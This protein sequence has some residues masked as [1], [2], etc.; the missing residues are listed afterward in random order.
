M[1]FIEK[2]GQVL[3]LFL[4]PFGGGIPAGVLL[5]QKLSLQWPWM[6]VLYFISDLILAVVFE[7]ILRY[8][9]HLSYHYSFLMKMRLAFRKWRDHHPQLSKQTKNPFVLIG[10]AFGVDPMTG[11]AAAMASGYGFIGGWLIAIAGDM[12]Y[13]SVIMISTLWL[14]HILG[15]GTWTIIIILILMVFIPKVVEKVRLNINARRQS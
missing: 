13:F 8:L 12:I 4:V 6:L 5:A 10:V 14:N 11:R 2:A 1:T 9:V 3:W 7:P 15:D